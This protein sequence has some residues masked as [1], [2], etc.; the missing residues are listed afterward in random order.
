MKSKLITAIVIVALILGGVGVVKM[1]QRAI[2]ALPLPASQPQTVQTAT[3]AE[4]SL[5]VTSRQLGE[6]RPYTSAELAPRITGHILSLSKREGDQVAKGEVVCIV[7]DRE[8]VDRAA[9]VEAEVLATRQRLAGA[10][11][12]YETQR[13]ITGRDEKLFAAGAISQEALERSG[14]ALDSARA[15]VEAYEESLKG[16][17][18]S[19]AAARLQTGYARMVAPFAGVV[20]RRLAEPG[21]LAVPGKA[22]LTI[23][24]VSPAKVVVQ[25]PQELMGKMRQGGK[26]Y[27]ANGGERLPAEVSR[28]HPALGRN[29]LGSL[30]VV[31]PQSPFGLPTGSTV[32]VELVMATVT[33][34]IVPE[35][36][37]VR[38][39]KGAFVYLV[40][41]GAVRTRP[42]ELLGSAGG[43]AAVRGDLPAGAVVAVGQENRLLTLSDGMQVTASGGKP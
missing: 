28:V 6:V 16:M 17:E 4:G 18:R 5:E 26:L 40:E 21:D 19:V 27:L 43:K 32:G 3:V 38:S 34:S 15:A 13:S 7:D 12:L 25:V 22:V 1:K 8:L 24:Q 14:S 39:E 37:L 9:A 31:L 42:V 30:E 20:T 36:A 10:R 29:L 33:G 2:A 35:N 23:E 41:N 11:S